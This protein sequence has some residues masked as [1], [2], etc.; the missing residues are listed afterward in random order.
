MK[1]ALA[2]AAHPDDIEFM[3]AGTLLLLRDAGYEIHYMNIADGSLG[4]NVYDAAE[5]AERRRAEAMRSAALIHA[6]Y[7]PSI[8]RDMEIY[9]NHETLAQL[10]PV[11]REIAPEILLTHGPYDYMEDHI[12]AG[13]LAVS[14]AFARGMRNFRCTP[15][16]AVDNEVAI[17][18]SLP[19][20]LK[21]QLN[22]PVLPELFV[23]ISGV[24][25]VKRAMLACHQ[26][27]KEWLDASQGLN[28]YLDDME[29][30]C[31]QVGALSGVFPLAEGWLRHNPI[32]FCAENFDP[33]RQALGEKIT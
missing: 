28:A 25:A 18:H 12:N 26:T 9:V 33:L 15:P 13:R 23:D 3:M 7:H 6:V 17:Y 2:V 22:R 21:D 27:Q 11:I 32:G 20:S 10:V 24:I 29:G 16:G 5:L 14:A 30:R 31:R 19:L 4:S 8:C 1:R